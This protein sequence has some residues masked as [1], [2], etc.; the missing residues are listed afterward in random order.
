MYSIHTRKSILL[1]RKEQNRNQ[2]Q[3]QNQT[4]VK[5]G[6]G[7]AS[8]HACVHPSTQGSHPIR[9]PPPET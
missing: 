5:G 8:V 6:A 3:N 4:A 9:Q 2:N 7:P 1:H